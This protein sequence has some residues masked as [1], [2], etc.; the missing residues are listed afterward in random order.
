M[1]GKTFASRYPWTNRRSYIRPCL[2]KPRETVRFGVLWISVDMWT[3]CGQF[4]TVRRRSQ[5]SASRLSR[6]WRARIGPRVTN[7]VK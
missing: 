3:T 7:P 5:Q 4:G 1:M 2:V 6:I